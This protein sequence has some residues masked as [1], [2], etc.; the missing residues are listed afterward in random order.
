MEVKDWDDIAYNFL[1]G[2]GGSV[3]VGRGWDYQG[4]HSR[5]YNQRSICIA[6]IGTFSEVA[7]SERSLN[8]CQQLIKEGVKL[9][10]LVEDYRLYGHR[11]LIPTISPGNIIY[12][13]IRTWNNWTEEVIPP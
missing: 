3:F 12:E 8:A 9:G 11:Q 1:I 13:I 2:S 5:I 10:K 7:P 6:F 4:A